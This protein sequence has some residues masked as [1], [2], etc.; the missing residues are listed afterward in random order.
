[1]ILLNKSFLFYQIGLVDEIAE[2][3]ADAIEKC[4]NF[5]A[6]FKKVSPVARALTKQSLRKKDLEEL[7]TNKEQDLQMFLFFVNQPAVQKSLGAYIQSLKK[8]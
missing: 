1:M 5:L 2:D 4:D 6:E 8:K 3:K 7:E